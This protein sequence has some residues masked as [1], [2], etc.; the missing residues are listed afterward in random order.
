MERTRKG[1]SGSH[2]VYIIEKLPSVRHGIGTREK[3]TKSSLDSR[4]FMG[5]QSPL[6]NGMTSGSM[7]KGL[8][9]LGTF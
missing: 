7:K 3:V 5:Q 4:T 1:F 9:H 2:S 8:F 6:T